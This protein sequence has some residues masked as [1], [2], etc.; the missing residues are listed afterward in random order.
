MCRCLYCILTYISLD[1]CPRV[2]SLDHM[3]LPVLIFLRNHHT[4]FHSGI[5]NLHF[6][7]QC[8]RIPVLHHPYQY[9]LLLFLDYSHTNWC[10]VKSQCHFDLYFLWPEMLRHIHWPFL[11]LWTHASSRE[12]QILSLVV[13]GFFFLLLFFFSLSNPRDFLNSSNQAEIQMRFSVN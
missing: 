12:E 5:T 11:L 7:Q 4:D 9:L 2:V 1:M 13:W 3:V 6:Y 8:I 10:E